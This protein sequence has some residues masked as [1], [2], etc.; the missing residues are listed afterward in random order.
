MLGIL[1]FNLSRDRLIAV[2]T[3]VCLLPVGT[4]TWALVTRSSGDGD[5]A[6]V[7]QYWVAPDGDDAASGSRDDPWATMQHAM[8]ESDDAPEPTPTPEIS[9]TAVAVGGWLWRLQ[10]NGGGP[11]EVD[12]SNGERPPGDGLPLRI[13]SS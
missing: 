10:S 13:G 7:L 12:M 3:V 11:V 9:G 5:Q 8:Y 6:L 2:L 4:T 1:R